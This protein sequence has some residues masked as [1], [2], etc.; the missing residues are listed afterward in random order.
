MQV[1]ALRRRMSVF[2]YEI[3][4][5]T[6]AFESET[7]LVSLKVTSRAF[8]R[9]ARGVTNVHLVEKTVI[10]FLPSALEIKVA[11]CVATTD[12]FYIAF[13]RSSL[14]LSLRD[15]GMCDETLIFFIAPVSQSCNFIDSTSNDCHRIVSLDFCLDLQCPSLVLLIGQDAHNCI[16]NRF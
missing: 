5:P 16:L 12:L 11:Q 8:G 1:I 15:D 13:F 7:R 4:S 9:V 3:G 14:L 10:K 6:D 2:I